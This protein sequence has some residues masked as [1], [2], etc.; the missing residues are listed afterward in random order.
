[1]RAH[2]PPVAPDRVV[3]TPMSVEAFDA[4]PES[5]LPRQY[6]RGKLVAAPR[7]GA[8]HSKLKGAVLGALAVFLD[9]RPG[10]GEV[11]IGPMDVVIQGP[12][13]PERYQPDVLFYRQ[14]RRSLLPDDDCRVPVP[15]LAVEI[16]S[17]ETR[18]LDLGH[19]RVGYARNG[20][21]ELWAVDPEACE[22]IIYRLQQDPERPAEVVRRG[23]ALRTDLLPGFELPG[24]RLFAPR[25]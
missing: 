25:S 23:G 17:P 3:E 14:A 5:T 2:Q 7:P 11:I 6:I 16:L 13:G 10:L 20:L 24:D 18:D 22:V 15:D 9:A 1:M 21:E 19:K 8:R 12:D 4:L